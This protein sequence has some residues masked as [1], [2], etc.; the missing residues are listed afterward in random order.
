VAIDR[1]KF[2]GLDLQTDRGWPDKDQ[3]LAIGD[4][5]EGVYLSRKDD[6]GLN[7]KKIYILR[8]AEG[9][10]VGVWGSTVLDA[11]MEPVRPGQTVGIE[12]LGSK[13]PKS[14]G[15]NYHDFYVGVDTA[16]GIEEVPESVSAITPAEATDDV[17]F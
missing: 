5:I 6:V 12:Y 9:E 14:G 13:K 4:S 11:R 15:K 16:A 8:T 1:R 2:K 3:Q 10:L 7:K 17:P